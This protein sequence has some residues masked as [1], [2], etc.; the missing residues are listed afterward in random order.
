MATYG[1]Y[2]PTTTLG[3]AM[4]N[5]DAF[6]IP[7]FKLN[8]TVRVSVSDAF[9][10]S[11]Y[12]GNSYSD[13]YSELYTSGSE[14]VAWTTQM[15]ANLQDIPGIYSQ[16]ANITFHYEGDFDTF[17]SGNDF[18]P[19]PEDVGRF[20]LSDINITWIY[21]PGGSFAGISGGNADNLVLRYTGAAGDIFLNAAASTFAGDFSLDLNTRARQVLEH[22]IGHSLGLSHPHSAFNN[23]VPTL[24][25]DFAATKNLGFD[26]LGFHIDS[27]LD[28]YKEYFTIMSYDDQQSLLPGSNVLFH[29]HT[30]MILDVIALQQAYG[31]GPGTSG[32]GNDTIQAGNAGYRTYFDKG[33]ID[34]IDLSVFYTEGAYLNMGV[35]ITGAAHLV[36]VGM[37]L[38]DAQTTIT[39]GGD[40]A[41]LRWFYGEYENAIG[42]SSGDLLIGNILNNVI[43]G[44]GGDDTI[45]G[46]GGNDTIF[47]GA[48][49]DSVGGNDGND[50]IVG[51]D[52]NDTLGGDNGDDRIN[53]GDGNDTIFGGAG[54]DELGGGAGDDIIVGMDG[55]D[56]IFGEDGAD[57]SNGGAGK[58]ILVGGAGNDE[59]GG[60]ADNDIIVG[61][62]GADTLFGEDGNDSMNGGP[63]ADIVVGNA[64]DDQ[65]GGGADNDIVVGNDGNDVIFG[66]DGNDRLNGGN[67]RDIVIGG[68]GNDEVG[69]G[70]GNDD[71]NG[72]SGDD[73]L[74][75][76]DGD[77]TLNGSTGNDVLLGMGGGDTFAFTAGDGADTIVDFTHA[78]DHIWFYGTNLHS[79]ADV[80]SH[81]TFNAATNTTT[82]SYSGGVVTLNSAVLSTLGAGDFIFT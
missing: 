66:E 3:R 25:S 28:M 46:G 14:E 77:D 59:L 69:G 58:D 33:G 20:N 51:Q 19:N 1:S 40:P 80:Q 60:G 64:G 36:G 45:T 48:G 55:D 12:L 57:R 74:F 78:G 39:F 13:F 41:H 18:T 32:S 68:A 2:T 16:F 34:T 63:G 9:S 50:I 31:E 30:P 37:S 29:A 43:D 56:T 47:G 21:R 82:I 61:E 6:G 54:N 75:G 71:L 27:A 72:G 44:L 7:D 11:D 17:T 65:L 5:F 62:N 67:G 26:Q 8:G 42:A 53:G 22:E 70:S 76:E 15:T 81:A 35:T 24:T 49:N 38:T 23:G 10:F 79:F 4:F 73:T 52:G